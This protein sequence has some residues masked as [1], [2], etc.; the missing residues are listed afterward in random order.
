MPIF[1]LILFVLSL[2]LTYTLDPDFGW[3]LY[4]GRAIHS[5]HSLV[6][7]LVGYSNFASHGVIDH[8]WLSHYLLYP[9]F[10]WFGYWPFLLLAYLVVAGAVWLT[11][12]EVKRRGV[13]YSATLI[14][15]LTFFLGLS[16]IYRVSLQLLLYF[17]VAGLV[18]I[19][20]SQVKL[21]MRLLLYFLIFLIG[22]N[23]H[24][25]FMLLVPIPILL[26][27]GRPDTKAP[28]QP[29]LLTLAVCS[30]ALLITPYGWQF[31]QTSWD[32]LRDP[33][34]KA[35]LDEWH[36][37]FSYPIHWFKCIVPLLLVIWIFT[38]R[39]FWQ[40]VPWS[41]LI[42]LVIYGYLG[43]RYQ[44]FFP[45]FL[46]LAIPAS[47]EGWQYLLKFTPAVEKIVQRALL[48]FVA[49]ILLILTIEQLPYLRWPVKPAEAVGYPQA[50][51][52]LL[53]TLPQC[54]G[55][56]FNEYT[57]GGY[58]LGF[59]GTNQVFVDGR[60]PQE[61][62]GEHSLLEIYEQ[63]FSDDPAVIGKALQSYQIHC[64]LVRPAAKLALSRAEVLIFGANGIQ[65]N[66]P[67][68]NLTHYL[69]TQPGWHAVYSDA[70]TLLLVD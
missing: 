38:V 16:L 42:L 18:W 67:T 37:L 57:W 17:G 20:H 4:L 44:R 30:L 2:P 8:E 5:T 61:K 63:F 25:G 19:A 11:Y 59:S 65:Q 35:H 39:R 32:Y 43:L 40:K 27:A 68:S 21:R 55:H 69:R 51:A 58:L 52:A 36:S 60:A 6:H 23:L 49:I 28:W 41:E 66:G 13:S 70:H 14:A 46:L 53:P 15:F 64:I 7:T 56:L 26:E 24:G 1:L 62:I 48:V 50:A 31:W 45:L 3:H 22:N 33:L 54:Q 34:Y 47:A 29:A 10:R 12:Q 9:L